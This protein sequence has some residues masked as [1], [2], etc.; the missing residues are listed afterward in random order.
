MKT[1]TY[2]SADMRGF[3]GEECHYSAIVIAKS[4]NYS[5]LTRKQ[6]GIITMNTPDIRGIIFDLDGVI[7]DTA[8]FHYRAWHRIAGEENVAFSAEKYYQR[9]S[10]RKREENLRVFTENLNIDEATKQAWMARKQGYYAEL[11]DQLQRGDELPGVMR[12]IEEAK[13]AKLKLAVGSASKNARQVLER[14]HLTEHF[15]VIGDGHV[16]ENSKPAPDI[17]LW[18]AD[19]LGL[20]PRQLLV[21]EDAQAGVQAARTGGFYVIALG[22]NPLQDAHAQIANLANIS[23]AELITLLS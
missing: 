4:I 6:A 16:V 14:L 9:M 13:A 8:E 23:L 15:E 10:G 18:V 5:V 12:I 22:E 19:S 11:R 17:F 21:L 3:L 7:A 1:V 2:C 20:L